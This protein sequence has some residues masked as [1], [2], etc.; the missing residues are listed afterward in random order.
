MITKF[1]KIKN[2][3]RWRDYS[4]SD[5]T[6]LDK[7][8]IIYGENSQGKTTLVSIIRSLVLNDSEIIL[9]RRTFKTNEKQFVKL[10]FQSICQ[11]KS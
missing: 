4:A 1:I 8:N 9:K 7:V 5:D 6:T 11:S 10:L 2:V 3:G